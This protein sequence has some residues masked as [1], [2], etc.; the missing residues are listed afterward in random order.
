MEKSF[1]RSKNR[2]LSA[3]A[4]AGY[5]LGVFLDQI[6][7]PVLVSG[8]SSYAQKHWMLQATL[9]CQTCHMFNICLRH[10]LVLNPCTSRLPVSAGHLVKS[11]VTTQPSIRLSMYL[12]SQL[13]SHLAIQLS[14][15]LA[16]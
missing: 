10:C 14:G 4:A 5:E 2:L 11:T 15:Y 13:A 6:V 9:F 8:N 7:L 3:L 12:S 1:V 16:A